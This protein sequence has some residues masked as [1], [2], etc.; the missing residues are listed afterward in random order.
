MG[1]FSG[2]GGMGGAV[3]N[4]AANVNVEV[5]GT[6]N[7]NKLGIGLQK[8]QKRFV[9]FG[10]TTIFL[11]RLVQSLT[12]AWRAL[13]GVVGVTRVA[14]ASEGLLRL[15]QAS[16]AGTDSL[17][18]FLGA[19]DAVG[20]RLED[21]SDLMQTVSERVDD[22]RSGTEKGI[23]DD[24]LRF[25]MSARTFQGANNGLDQ[26]MVLIRELDKL[27][28]ERRMA[29]LEKLL[30]GD[31]ARRFGQLG[32]AEGIARAMRDATEQGQVLSAE[33]LR[34]GQ[35]F[36]IAARLLKR[37][38]IALSNNIGTVL[39]PVLTKG[40]GLLAEIVGSLS[41]FFNSQ[42]A[43]FGQHVANSLEPFLDKIRAIKTYIDNEVMDSGEMLARLGQGLLVIGLA[44]SAVALG[45]LVGQL[46]VA[47][48]AAV[49]LAVAVDD[50]MTYMRGGDS[51]LE[52]IMG[53]TPALLFFMEGMKGLMEGLREAGLKF[54]DAFS[55]LASGP[56]GPLLL[57]MLGAAAEFVGMMVSGVAGLLNLFVRITNVVVE[58][59]GLFAQVVGV[60]ATP[61]IAAML[62][63]DVSG[64]VQR[65]QGRRADRFA[66][67]GGMWS[68]LSN[69]FTGEGP[70][71]TGLLL[72][73]ARSTT[74]N[75]TNNISA[76]SSNPEGFAASAVDAAGRGLSNSVGSN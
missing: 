29:G 62:G 41:D 11:D 59:L 2:L 6:G 16:G 48:V 5:K 63:Q 28:P 12:R 51:V 25:G 67:T 14:T 40:A 60:F 31:L 70:T 7:L 22:L 55:Q 9:G 4:F 17:Q 10:V 1:M 39:L 13:N 27:E 34:I 19:A 26:F 38:T 18:A 47:S 75:Q 68:S 36:A 66:R 20:V 57:A 35:R 54:A 61:A 37:V 56:A 21:V 58:L 76:T 50:L 24:F 74:I 73:G 71:T 15:A 32:S 33:Q 45:P 8:L 49:L 65:E 69:A 42:A 44:L 3:A 23:S 30:G 52:D 46:A 64:A 72:G 43:R 53:R